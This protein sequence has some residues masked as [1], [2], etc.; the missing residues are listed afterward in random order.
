MVVNIT[1]ESEAKYN[2][3]QDAI[4]AYFKQLWSDNDIPETENN[5]IGDWA[6]VAHFGSFDDPATKVSTG[7]IVETASNLA[8][9]AIKGLFNEGIDWVIERTEHDEEED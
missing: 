4:S 5:Y 1:P 3:L 8:P 2:A 6:L 9:H 7:Y